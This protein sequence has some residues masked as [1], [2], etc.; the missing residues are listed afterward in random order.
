[1]KTEF[2]TRSLNKKS[3]SYFI[4]IFY[5]GLE[6]K[7]SINIFWYI[8]LCLKPVLLYTPYQES[9]YRG[10]IFPLHTT[11][12]YFVY[13]EC[14]V[15]SITILSLVCDLHTLCYMFICK[16][17]IIYEYLPIYIQLT[18][19]FRSMSIVFKYY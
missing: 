18:I 6:Y 14:S 13:C 8:M 5:Y 17:I 19:L 9:K 1:M 3:I 10:Q 12:R 15:Y 2:D 16:H 4:V 7:I 11:T